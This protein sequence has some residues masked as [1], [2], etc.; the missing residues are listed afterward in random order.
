[1]NISKIEEITNRGLQLKR[2]YF[3]YGT[4]DSITTVRADKVE[5][6]IKELA[7]KLKDEENPLVLTMFFYFD[8][9]D[10]TGMGG[11]I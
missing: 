6:L 7:I 4:V 2:Q 10:F 3:A 8:Y 9:M 1:V 5:E 11:E